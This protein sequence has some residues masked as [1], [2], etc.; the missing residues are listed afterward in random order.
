MIDI[1]DLLHNRLK[2]N[3]C[4][5]IE[6]ESDSWIPKEFFELHAIL[7]PLK[8]MFLSVESR[9]CTLSEIVPLARQVHASWRKIFGV[10]ETD[11]GKEILHLIV[12]HFIGRLL[13]NNHWESIATDLLTPLGR[14]E[15]RTQQR[16][17]QTIVGSV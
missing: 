12:A 3:S 6:H 11:T 17:F 1:L 2:I 16:G 10:L 4:L 15:L 9:D 14:D 8:V 7:L 13:T 5:L